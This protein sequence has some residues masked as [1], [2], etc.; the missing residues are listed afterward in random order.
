[1]SATPG[2][3]QPRIATTG[4]RRAARLAGT[5]AAR[6]PTRV[7]PAHAMAKSDGSMTTTNSGVP[8]G[9]CRD[10]APQLQ[11]YPREQRSEQRADEPHEGALDQEDAQYLRAGRAHR[12]QD[13]DLLRFLH[14]GHDEHARDAERDGDP[15]KDPDEGVREDL[16]RHGAEELR[17]GAD[18]A[19]DVEIAALADGLG[20]GLRRE[21]VVHLHVEARGAAREIEQILRGAQRHVD[22]ALVDALVAEIEY[23]DHG[24]RGS[25]AVR[26]FQREFVLDADRR[27]PWRARCRRWRR[28]APCR[29]GRR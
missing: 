16:R 23:A 21:R 11:E 20:D 28:S 13:A 19:V 29:S 4:S 12:P 24:Q 5:A 9:F 1:M 14:D 26:G 7:A 18:P 6:M 22:I 10:S 25:G 2:K 3:H 17:I 8:S 15:D 27:D